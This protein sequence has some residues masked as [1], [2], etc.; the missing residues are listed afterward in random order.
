MKKIAHLFAL[1]ARDFENNADTVRAE[2][3][4]LCEQFPLYEGI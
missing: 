3:A 1:T 2:V 4:K